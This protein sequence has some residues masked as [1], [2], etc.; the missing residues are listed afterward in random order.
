MKFLKRNPDD[1]ELGRY[2]EGLA[3]GAS[4]DQLLLDLAGQSEEFLSKYRVKLGII[5]ED[6]TQET[7]FVQIWEKCR[8]YTITS[9][10]RAYAMYKAVE[11]V[12]KQEIPG[13][14]VECGVWKGGSWMVAAY[15]LLLLRDTVRSIYLYD[16]FAGMKE[17]TVEDVRFDGT[18]AHPLWSQ[19]RE[20]QNRSRWWNYPLEEVRRNLLATGYPAD[21]LVFVEGR[22]EETIPARVPEQIAAL[23][24]DTDWYESTLHELRHLYPRLAVG[25][26]LIID[27]YGWWTGSRKATEQYFQGNGI[28]VLLCRIDASG[29]RM[30]VKTRP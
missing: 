12:V 28:H 17:P 27:D 5:T 2:R 3:S 7:S 1:A 30:G 18:A 25:G 15:T 9:M 29:A 16:T 23:R 22:V 21:N 19:A 10:E 11:H 4:R 20:D 24:L 13:D 6:M 14:I 8:N 26:V